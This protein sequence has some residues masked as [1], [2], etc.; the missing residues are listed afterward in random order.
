ML[1]LN[2]VPQ[3]VVMLAFVSFAV[4]FGAVLFSL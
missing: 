1:R 4:Y 2:Q 3:R